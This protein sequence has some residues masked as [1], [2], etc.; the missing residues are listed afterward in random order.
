MV[1]GHQGR[2]PS[3]EACFNLKPPAGEFERFDALLETGAAFSPVD[4]AED[5]GW[6]IIHTA[7][8]AGRPRGALVTHRNLVCASVQ[9]NLLLQ[10]TPADVHLN[11]LPLFHVG[12]LFMA[13]QSFCAGALNVN[14]GRFDAA[15]AA[16]LIERHRVTVLFDF[17]PILES[18]LDQHESGGRAA[19]LAAAGDRPGAARGDRP[20]PDADGRDVLLHVRADRDRGHRHL[21]PLR[22]AARVGRPPGAVRAGGAAR[23][24]R[25]PGGGGRGR[26][27]RGPGPARFAGYWDLPEDTARTFRGG[28]HHTGDL[29][30]F[31]ADG[32]LFYA[33][34]KPDKE[35][36]KPGGENVYPA[37][38]ET[39]ILQHPD[40]ER[41]VVFGVPDPRWKE[42][43]K[44]VCQ[45]KPGRQL[46]AADLIAFVGGR[47]ASFKKPRHVEFVAAM[48][49]APDGSPDRKKIKDAHGG[50]SG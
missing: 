14:M 10:M 43:V 11:L 22:R 45:L 35:L 40:V 26:R 20:L 28:W 2:L 15:A 46:A 49:L 42:A 12:G 48:P 29:G 21:R 41:A 6:T 8:V 33:G 17:A 7:A 19:R 16:E 44:A 5:D 38:V 31:D 36:I 9:L 27:D 23:R 37:E 50:E 13:V 24:G 3:V 18:I 4:A 25:S 34:R 1:R 39:A 30:R 47:I 32:Y